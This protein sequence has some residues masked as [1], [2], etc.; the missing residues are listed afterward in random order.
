MWIE[1]VAAL[2]VGVSLL[3]LVF[4]PMFTPAR[5]QELSALDLEALDAVEDTRSGVALT[6]L[7]EIEFDRETGKLSDDDYAFLKQKYT[8][9]ALTALRTESDA[10]QGD[11]LEAQVAARVAAIKAGTGRGAACQGCGSGVEPDARFCPA[12]GRPVGAPAA[13]ANCG[14][15]LPAGSRFCGSC[16]GRVAA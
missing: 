7:R 16:G 11:D 5:P 3:W 10:P 4:E 9:E 14:S 1:A 8:V 15:A 13:C 2:L 6:A 12:C